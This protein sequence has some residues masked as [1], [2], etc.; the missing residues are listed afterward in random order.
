MFPL[1]C[2]ALWAQRN[3]NLFLSSFGCSH[4]IQQI[5]H[6]LFLSWSTE[7][8]DRV[9]EALFSQGC[10]PGDQSTLIPLANIVLVVCIISENFERCCGL[11][12]CFVG[13][14]L[15]SFLFVCLFLV[16]GAGLLHTVHCAKQQQLFPSLS[17]S[18]LILDGVF[19]L[20]VLTTMQ[21]DLLPVIA[22]LP[23]LF[24]FLSFL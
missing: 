5:R 11:V 6:S 7:Q 18:L 1:F 15:L 16:V 24:L 10:L 9:G 3:T 21:R 22:L 4:Q 19:A 13:F 17:S 23:R 20:F 2:A 8:N 14:F 12:F